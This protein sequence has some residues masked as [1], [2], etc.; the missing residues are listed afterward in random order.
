MADWTARRADQRVWRG[1]KEEEEREGRERSA[2][3]SRAR[4]ESQERRD[5]DERGA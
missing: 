3:A 2:K 5:G 1:K 4:R